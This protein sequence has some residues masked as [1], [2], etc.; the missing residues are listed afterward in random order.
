MK[1]ISILFTLAALSMLGVMKVKATPLDDK[2]PEAAPLRIVQAIPLPNV[3]GR[4]DHFTADQKRKL[5][6]GSALGNNTVE[7]VDVFAGRVVHTRM[8]WS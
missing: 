6:I 4:I 1:R 3:V 2:E 5:V 8:K 7:V